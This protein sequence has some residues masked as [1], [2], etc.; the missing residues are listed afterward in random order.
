MKFTLIT[1][2]TLLNMP[3]YVSILNEIQQ[4]SQL[5]FRFKCRRTYCIIHVNAE[6]HK[7]QI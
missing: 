4:Q 3:A 7:H 6:H 5:L 2:I 1:L